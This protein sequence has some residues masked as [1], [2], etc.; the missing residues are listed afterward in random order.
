[1]TLTTFISVSFTVI[2]AIQLPI[3]GISAAKIRTIHGIISVG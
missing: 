1:L 2:F 3:V